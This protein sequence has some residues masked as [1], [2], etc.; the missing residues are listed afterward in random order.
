MVRT[1]LQS[2]RET[3]QQYLA[4]LASPHLNPH[5]RAEIETGLTALRDTIER[6]THALKVAAKAAADDVIAA[7]E[8]A[9]IFVEEHEPKE[10]PSE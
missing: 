10:E 6:E 7:G 5:A 4:A 1:Y 9:E 3:E 2:L 8:R